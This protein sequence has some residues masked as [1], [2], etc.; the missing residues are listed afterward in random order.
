MTGFR[1]TR[2]TE[3]FSSINPEGKKV[4]INKFGLTEIAAGCTRFAIIFDRFFVCYWS[5]AARDGGGGWFH[6]GRIFLL[7]VGCQ[8]AGESCQND[9]V[10]GQQHRHDQ[11]SQPPGTDPA[12]IV[13]LEI[14]WSII[15][16]SGSIKIIIV[17]SSLYSAACSNR[18]RFG[19]KQ[20]WGSFR[21][22][23]PGIWQPRW[24]LLV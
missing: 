2:H 9:G 6:P 14:Y 13:G 5:D 3:A 24:F 22:P 23:V 7:G 10:E 18:R 12:R 11:K 20:N 19:R 15:Y 4:S 8:S 16:P 21:K 1:M 17:I